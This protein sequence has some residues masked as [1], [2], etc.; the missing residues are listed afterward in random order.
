LPGDADIVHDFP[1]RGARQFYLA[2]KDFSEQEC[3]TN[4]NSQSRR[5]A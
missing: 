1:E 5:H 3:G 2:R 4:E